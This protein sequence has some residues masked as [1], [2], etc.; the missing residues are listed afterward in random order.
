[1]KFCDAKVW[2]YLTGFNM[3]DLTWMRHSWMPLVCKLKHDFENL[4][5]WG[6]NDLFFFKIFKAWPNAP[7]LEM[8]AWF[9]EILIFFFFWEDDYDNLFFW[10]WMRYSRMPLVCE[11]MHDF[12]KPWYLRKR[13]FF[14]FFKIDE[15]WSNAPSLERDAWFLEILIFFFEK[16]MMMILMGQWALLECR[17]AHLEP[18]P[19]VAFS[20]FFSTTYGSI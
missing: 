14:F 5:F 2:I 12:W 13:R 6:K 20:T 17:L 7:S 19:V 8:D 1:M 3:G 10:K 15:V 9:L 11:L 4:D 18:S 16:M